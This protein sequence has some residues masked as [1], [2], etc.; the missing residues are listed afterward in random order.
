MSESPKIITVII[1]GI[2]CPGC[3]NETAFYIQ[4]PVVMHVTDDGAECRSDIEWDDDSHSQCPACERSGKLAEFRARPHPY[5]V[6]SSHGE[7]TIDADGR[8]TECRTD[9]DDPD[10][11]LHLKAITRFD[12]GEWHRHW[13]KPENSR[14]DILD[15]GYWYIEPEGGESFY[16]PPDA[17][18]RK[19]IA[20]ILLHRKRTDEGEA[21]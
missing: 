14:I 10:G 2:K 15:L 16:E 13:G 19:E 18:W 8:I 9:N 17:Q 3:G 6:S 11:G 7:L 12:L 1:E 20:E 4:S 21:A 5:T